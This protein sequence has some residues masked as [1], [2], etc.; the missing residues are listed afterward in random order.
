MSVTVNGITK[1]YDRITVDN[2]SFELEKNNPYAILGRNGSGKSTIIKIMLGLKKPTC[3]QVNISK[4]LKIG[5]LPEERGIYYD[6]TVDEHLDLFAKLSHIKKIEPVKK[7][8]LERL[9]LEKFKDLK[10][11]FL[12][13]GT[14]QKVQL[15][16]TLINDPDLIILDEPF[17]GLDPI[18]MSL[19]IDVIKEKSAD[20]Y[21]I[22]SSHQMNQVEGLCKEVLFLNQ[23]RVVAQGKINDLKEK[24]GCN[25]I[26]VPY[27]EEL[28]KELF[29]FSTYQEGNELII[30]AGYQEKDY[31]RILRKIMDKN[32]DLSYLHYD[33]IALNDLF[34]QLLGG[35]C[36]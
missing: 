5:Y 25:K 6:S 1:K 29:D 31:K 9:E 18:N 4:D 22:I 26:R 17:S 11:K 2:I 35:D 15:A 23:G 13:K 10:L 12:S 30:K 8:W 14:A 19:F 24:F 36:Y 32:L 33:N 28:Q 7:Y 3:G 21:T 16:I 34:I 20:K 27:N